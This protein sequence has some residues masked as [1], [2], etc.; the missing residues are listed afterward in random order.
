MILPKAI[1]IGAVAAAVIA[2][3]LVVYVLNSQNLPSVLPNLQKQKKIEPVASAYK[4]NTECEL[5]YSL[6]YGVYPDNQKIPPVVLEDLVKK[7]QEFAPWKEILENDTSRKSFFSAKLPDDFNE[8]FISAIM[9]DSSIN[10]QLKD[11]AMLLTDPE[12]SIKLKSQ[13]EKYNCK[14][15]FDSRK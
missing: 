15:Y 10:P 11:I 5:I 6:A 14:S 12:G 2:A 1:I 3:V 13:Y 7:H 8:V 9:E 4:I